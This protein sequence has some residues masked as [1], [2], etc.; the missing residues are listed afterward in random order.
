MKDSTTHYGL[1][2]RFLHWLLALLI[3]AQF[4]LV[5]VFTWIVPEHGGEHHE[6]GTA[7]LHETMM[8]LHNSVG[9]LIL[10]FGLILMVWRLTVQSRQQLVWRIKEWLGISRPL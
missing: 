5:F 4:T 2:S 10:L 1:V 6:H 7:S 8:M 9:L 3:I